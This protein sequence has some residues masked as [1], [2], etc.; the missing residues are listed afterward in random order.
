MLKLKG[1]S[2]LPPGSRLTV[3]HY[4]FIGYKSS[5]LS[6]EAHV[7]VPESGLFEVTLK[8]REG[9]AF[10]PNVSDQGASCLRTIVATLR[11]ST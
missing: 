4:D 9:Q 8:P 6:Q 3:F 2:N 7:V 11:I 10:E 5:A 1:A